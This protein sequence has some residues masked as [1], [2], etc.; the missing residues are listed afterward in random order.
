MK[1]F[2]SA[3]LAAALCVAALSVRV[4]AQ[5]KTIV[6]GEGVRG[7]MYLPAYIAEEKSFFKRRGLD[8]RL[9][10]FSRSNDINALVSGD[11]EFDLTAPDKVIHSAIGGFPVKMIMGTARGLNLALVVH[12][13]IRSA[14]DIRGKSVAITGFSGLPYTGLLLSLKELG[15]SKDQI[16]PLNIG[17]KAARFEALVSN[18]VPAAI[19]DPPYTTMAAKEGYKLLVD[20]AP[21]DVS[22][23]RNIVA[24]SEKSLREDSRTVTRFVA[25]L[26]EGMQFNRNKANK[27]ESMRILAKYLR[28]PL[29]KNHAMIEEGYE[30]Y[31]D[32]MLKKPYVDPNAMNL[33]VEIIAETNPK[34]R[35]INV[36]SLIDSSFVERLDRDGV[37]DR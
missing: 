4:S 1:G 25:A 22:Y 2:Y 20:L 5:T 34:A 14:A 28:V 33:L 7:A 16:V 17:G 13:S 19:L 31:R 29:E 36:G 30:I 37:F 27:D 15:L 35:A 21:L 18:K 3:C 10:T 12:P 11:I 6:I 23:L 26:V 9:V 8:T 32:M 24:V